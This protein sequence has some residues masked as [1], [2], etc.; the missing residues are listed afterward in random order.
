M[1]QGQDSYVLG[2]DDTVDFMYYIL[3]FRQAY[4]MPL[5]LRGHLPGNDALAAVSREL[6]AYCSSPA[7]SGS[8]TYFR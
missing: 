4:Y 7:K 8:E 5:N 3:D 6:L 2:R 1:P